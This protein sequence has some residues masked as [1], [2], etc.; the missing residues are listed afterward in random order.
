MWDLDGNMKINQKELN[1]PSA[2]ACV[3]DGQAVRC[4]LRAKYFSA[5]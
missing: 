5:Q 2:T 3:C 4:S 1:N